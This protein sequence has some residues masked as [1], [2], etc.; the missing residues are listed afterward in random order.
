MQLLMSYGQLYLAGLLWTIQRI[1]LRRDL[2]TQQTLTAIHDKSCA[3]LGLCSSLSVLLDQIKIPAALPKVLC[4]FL[5][6]GGISV[7]HIVIP[8][9]LNVNIY[10]GTVS[11]EQDTTLARPS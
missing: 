5:Y 4:I 2:H 9:S 1:T 8:S 11:V 3:W 7:L 6:L 10:N